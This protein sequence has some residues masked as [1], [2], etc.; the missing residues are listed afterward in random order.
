MIQDQTYGMIK[1]GF[2]GKIS[3]PETAANI[4]AYLKQVKAVK[5]NEEIE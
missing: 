3:V 5:N 4:H 2:E 1:I